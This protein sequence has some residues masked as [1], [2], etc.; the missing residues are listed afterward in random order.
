VSANAQS[1]KLHG[2]IGFR[3]GGLGQFHGAVHRFMIKGPG[4]ARAAKED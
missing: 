2:F 1:E 3:P 4:C